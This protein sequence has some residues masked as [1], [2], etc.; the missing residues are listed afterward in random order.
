VRWN[1][2]KSLALLAV[3]FGLIKAA[4]GWVARGAPEEGLA[5][6]L[7]IL[8]FAGPVMAL[9]DLRSWRRQRKRRPLT[10]PV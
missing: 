10:S 9:L 7:L 8:M 1:Y 4:V 2:T 3:L 6:F 5:T